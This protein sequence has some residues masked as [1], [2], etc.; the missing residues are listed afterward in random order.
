MTAQ[1]RLAF[2]VLAVLAVISAA[3]L[4][5]EPEY[6]V[7]Y[8]QGYR[9]WTHVMSYVIGPQSPAYERNGGL[10]NFYANDKAVEGYRTGQF[11]DGSILID[12]RNKTEEKD[13]VART[14]DRSA[15]A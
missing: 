5:A 9:K 15:S 14:G 12:E 4:W 2:V 7:E 13:G 3:W 11:P 8:P 6:T 1:G 10:H